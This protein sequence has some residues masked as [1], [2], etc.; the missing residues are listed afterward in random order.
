MGGQLA[1][2][3]LNSREPKR[4]FGYE[5][6]WMSYGKKEYCDAVKLGESKK[7][8]GR[9]EGYRAVLE[10]VSGDAADAEAQQDKGDSQHIAEEK[11]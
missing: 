11:I 10:R 4:R 7:G 1:W 2:L 3:T 8:R 5:Q 9:M 6:S